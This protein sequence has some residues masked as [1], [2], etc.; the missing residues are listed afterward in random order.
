MLAAVL[1]QTQVPAAE[2]AMLFHVLAVDYDGT[3]ATNGHVDDATVDALVRL[4]RSGRRIVLVTGRLLAPLLEAFPQVGLCERVVAENGA[5][6][7]DPETRTERPLVDPPPR[8]FVEKLA[9][10]GVPVSEVGHVI[11]ATCVPY[12][13]VVLETIRDLALELQIVFNKGAV[14]VLPTGVNKASGLRVALTELGFSPHNTVGIGDAE[15]DEAFLKLCEVSAAVDNALEAVKQQADLVTAGAESAGVVELINRLVTDDLHDQHFRPGRGILL[16]NKVDGE[17]V[18]VPIYGTRVLV[19]GD[20]AAGKSKLAVGVLEQLMEREYQTCVIDPEGDFQTVEGPIVL[21]TV[22]RAPTV[23]DVMNVI[24]QVDKSCVISLFAAKT[25]EQPPLYSKIYRALQEY[26][27]HTG[28]PHWNIIDEAHYPIAS[29]WKPIHELNLEDFRSVMYVTAAPEQMPREILSHIDLFVAISDDPARLLQEYCR[30]L[31]EHAPRLAH[32]ADGKKHSAV[33]W[34]RNTGHPF[35][36]ERLP[37]RGE[38]QRHQHQ[39][40]DGEMD[41]ANQFYFRGPKGE[42]NLAA[43]NLRTFIQLAEGV[44]DAT[45]THHLKRGDYGRWFRVEIQDDALAAVAEQLQRSEDL[46]PEESRQQMIEAIRKLYVKE[47]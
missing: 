18:W 34:W 31:G 28:R 35:W 29:S 22:E 9:E 40:F 39:Y 45:W 4:R 32:P 10:R 7:Y 36:F 41:P 23:E 26:R 17:E 8:E 25:D 14:M 3:L 44:D 16:G 6:L 13:T 2:Q 19:T 15:N 38:H 12:E 11:V 24:R 42:L 43:G 37:A 47:I 30:R 27:T 1:A 20:S 46:S 33:A 21:G 5:L